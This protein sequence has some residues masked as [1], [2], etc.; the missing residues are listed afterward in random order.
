MRTN[1]LLLAAAAL[2]A[3]AVTASAQVYSA[4]VVG[5]IN[6][7]LKPG[8]NLIANQLTN[9]NNNVNIVLTNLPASLD[10]ATIAGFN[11]AVQNFDQAQT[12]YNGVGWVDPDFNA[13]SLTLTP[14]KG[15][16]LNN[17]GA[18][19]TVTL[20]GEVPQ[21]VTATPI[22]TGFGMYA[23][24]PPVVSGLT[25]NGFPATKGSLRVSP[26][27]LNR[28]VRPGPDQLGRCHGIEHTVVVAHDHVE[29]VEGDP[30]LGTVRPRKF[31]QCPLEAL[32]NPF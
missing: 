5:Y 4:N 25:T 20:I 17:P 29:V 16:F 13:S 6:I 3:G 9:G 2:A 23:S 30:V 28:S 24:V 7:T 22:S 12:W 32:R 11:S 15:F 26:W 8:F 18:Q 31:E 21:G 19:V 1:K 10:N 14:G 27:S